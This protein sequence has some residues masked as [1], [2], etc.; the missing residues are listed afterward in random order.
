MGLQRTLSGSIVALVLI[1]VLAPVRGESS[2]REARDAF[3]AVMK[4]A[5][6]TGR[7]K[8]VNEIAAEEGDWIAGELRKVVTHDRA[9][10]VGAA[11]AHALGRRGDSGDLRFLIAAVNRLKKRPIVLAGAVAGIGEF[12]DARS[13]EVLFKVGRYWMAKERGPTQAAIRALGKIRAK[14]AVDCLIKLYRQTYPS[15]GYLRGPDGDLSIPGPTGDGIA[16]LLQSYRP[17]IET[18]L[19]RL[20][21]RDIH[22]VADWESWWDDNE[23]GF[24]PGSV[25]E[26]P[27]RSLGLT[28]VDFGYRVTRPS[29]SWRWVE[30]P[31]SGFSRTAELRRDGD[32]D[33]RFSVLAYSV[34]LR[35][36]DNAPDMLERQ[37][38][39]LLDLVK[40]PSEQVWNEKVLLG[41]MDAVRQSLRGVLD[42]R[43]VQIRQTVLVKGENLYMVRVTID[44]WATSVTRTSVEKFVDSFT[45]LE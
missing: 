10:S 40:D 29:G 23:K 7:I 27:N 9:Q 38:K 6:E 12:H 30:K 17:F 45:F 3:R 34:R 28:D 11:A 16:S 20:T 41:G 43:G 8:A 32:L 19:V 18:C 36:P 22:D 1:T 14:S 39:E 4:E 33:A 24:D 44:A 42:G 21:G 15:G 25:K 5:D 31:E 35:N 37:K 13:V 2:E 26:D